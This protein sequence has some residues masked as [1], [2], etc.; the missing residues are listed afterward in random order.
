MGVFD[1]FKGLLESPNLDQRQKEI[2][3]S[4]QKLAKP[5]WWVG[6]TEVRERLKELLLKNN[7]KVIEDVFGNGDYKILLH[8]LG[9]EW[10]E[11]MKYVWDHCGDFNYM[12]N[13]YRRSFRADPHSMVY[14]NT[15]MH[16]LLEL[17][18]LRNEGFTLEIY[19]SGDY[20]RT[21]IKDERVIAEL[22]AMEINQGNLEVY[23]QIK[24][25]IYGDNNVNVISREMI[26]GLL[27]AKH[28]EGWKLV[29]ELLL[30]AKLQ[31]GLRQNIV[32]VLDECQVGA[33][34]H[35]YK[36]IID[37][38]LS[39]FSS[40][41]R[42]MD[43]W[44]GLGITNEK[45]STVSKCLEA[46][47]NALTDQTVRVHNLDSEDS[48]LIYMS[49]WAQSIYDINEAVNMVRKLIDS[50][51][52]HKILVAMYFAGQ[53][54]NPIF[55][56]AVSNEIIRRAAL[57]ID[58]GMEKQ[59]DY[60]LETLAW[61]IHT[62]CPG[63]YRYRNRKNEFAIHF[64]YDKNPADL[65]RLYLKVLKT[66]PNKSKTFQP[67]VFP[68][69]AVEFE[70]SRIPAFL[71]HFVALNKRE[72]KLLDEILNCSEWMDIHTRELI[73]RDYLNTVS[74]DKQRKWLL[75]MLSD[76]SST[77]R[78]EALK[79]I[80]NLEPTPEEYERLEQMLSTKNG[81]MKKALIHILLRQSSK[82]MEPMIIR[83]LNDKNAEKRQGALDML[84]I[85]KDDKALHLVYTNCIQAA[86]E[87]ELLNDGD[88]LI[89]NKMTDVEL[90]SF[91]A[92]NGYGLVNVND[93]LQLTMSDE[94]K[95]FNSST[96]FTMNAGEMKR[97]FEG[98]CK[99]VE[100]NKDYE[101][102]ITRW[103][104]SRESVIL[105]SR[106]GLLPYEQRRGI[107]ICTL[108]DYPLTSQ[109]RNY[110]ETTK[111][112]AYQLVQLHFALYSYITKDYEDDYVKAILDIFPLKEI[113][114]FRD[115]VQKQSYA[116]HA[117]VLIDAM[118]GEFSQEVFYE[119]A[120]NMMHYLLRT[121]PQEAFAK[122]YKKKDERRYYP[123]DFVNTNNFL[124]ASQISFWSGMLCQYGTEEHENIVFELQ[125]EF[126]KRAGY[127]NIKYVSI[128][129]WNNAA[130]RGMDISDEFMREL[131]SRPQSPKRISKVT[132]DSFYRRIK[133]FEL[134]EQLDEVKN[135]ALSRVMEI[136]LKRGDVQTEVSHLAKNIGEF[137]GTNYFVDLLVAFGKMPFVRGYNFLSSDGGTKKE[138]F[139]KLLK[140]CYPAEGDNVKTLETCLK[141]KKITD[142]RLIE[143][144]MYAPQWIDLVQQYLDWSGLHMACWYFHAHINERF[145]AEKETIVARYSKI[146]P[147]SFNEGAFDA[148]WF[149]EAYRLL[150]EKRFKQVYQAAKYISGGGNHK[151]SQLYADA[152]LGNIEIKDFKQ[153]IIDTRNKDKL[154]AYGLIKPAKDEKI[155]ILE[156]YEYIHEYLKQSK[157]YGAQR[158]AS[159]S[160]AV[161]V[162]LE[163]LART[164]G[165]D[166]VT[167]L[168]WNMEIEKLDS[169]K[170][171]YEPTNVDNITIWLEINDEG[172][173]LILVEKDDKKLKS[174]PAKLRKH[175]Y[176]EEI[177]SVKKSLVDQAKRARVIFEDGMCLGTQYRFD[178]ICNIQKHPVIRNIIK[179]L[180]LLYDDN[181]NG[182]ASLGYPCIE[183]LKT[184]SGE[185]ISLEDDS[186][187]RV[188]H[189]VDF[190]QAGCW[191]DYQKD[192]YERQVRQPFKQIFRELYL[193]NVDEQSEGNISRRYAGHQVQQ[194]K[195]V[196]LLRTRDWTVSYEDGLQKVYHDADVIG[197][198]YSMADWFSPADIE[199]P[200]LETV[201]FYD[202]NDYT[203]MNFDSVP[204]K[205]FS[206]TMRDLD[207]VVSIA[208]VGGVDPEAS[209]STIEMRAVV[210][211]ESLRLFKLDNVKIEGKHARIT[212]KLGEYDVH[213]GSGVV[214][215]QAKGS[216][217][218]IPVQ[219]QKRGRLFLPFL[220]ADPRTAEVLTKILF[221]AEDHKIKDPSILDQLV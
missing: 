88:K 37:N 90:S 177:K 5:D 84:H 146:A 207:L 217:Y 36:I 109:W 168:T 7:P 182:Q 28:E 54:Q 20:D 147:R 200:T 135:R 128:E 11:Q 201:Q 215:K 68:W 162:A 57:A 219:S 99:I 93:S 136:E 119:I 178:E 196:A 206:E 184:I 159:E 63:M 38:N 108:D 218:I 27:K 25:I 145:S 64:G 176:V 166:D 32:E 209:L 35:I 77:V 143:A 149:E 69:G 66:L 205:I 96:I 187:V 214:H 78:Q 142:K 42:A 58:S 59:E 192:I 157:K 170:G 174:I 40:V 208:H 198:M 110:L 92:A 33:F 22:I 50:N 210:I 194:K 41:I 14:F 70:P 150:G 204:P 80:G 161:A 191:S 164:A 221:L 21:K 86:N 87:S 60:D 216:V 115:Y 211:N 106:Q 15:N 95:S 43:V 124:E 102:E 126:Y 212:G 125:Y 71:I 130:K 175:P 139:S 31:E 56:H 186:Y 62:A 44:T 76:R 79:S 89:L 10:A 213:L 100:Q 197:T 127:K 49:L 45:P 55:E 190:Y 72:N 199:A 74:S 181:G 23:E 173:A 153:V 13:L 188:A 85:I 111:L 203:L 52:K 51:Q 155:D 91:D 183:G 3:A 179:D 138:M 19:L 193:P 48:M 101:Y 133:S 220:D 61:A 6:K 47:Y 116:K 26:R 131:L 154:M 94:D 81:N 97:W 118:F 121:V 9:K 134:C 34:L 82:D 24:A 202:R 29:G 141:D 169:I 185:I 152:H 1:K 165:Y 4:I 167:R 98:L 103:N 114:Q 12:N 53:T 73:T 151:R 16:R 156:R 46:G 180:V 148:L 195:T 18:A 107:R 132:G 123:T 140:N 17:T 137:Y 112:N 160:R 8:L 75:T 120:K 163:N 39:R 30:A 105:G 65:I 129:D 83:L 158:R 67:S 189:A 172:E 144:A 113:K 117:S 2:V 104:N 171:F 122:P